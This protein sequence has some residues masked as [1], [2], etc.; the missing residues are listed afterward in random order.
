MIPGDKKYI[1]LINPKI[2]KLAGQDVQSIEGCGSI[3]EGSYVVN[4]KPFVSIS[5]YTLKKEYIELEY[6]SIDY[7]ADKEPVFATY[8]NKEW[9]VQHEMDHLD[10]ITI[11]DKGALFDFNKLMK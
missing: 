6:G 9:I 11:K 8:S 1:T 4:R 5:G 7:I 2:L 10:G 3:P